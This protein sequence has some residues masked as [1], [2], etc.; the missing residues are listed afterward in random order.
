MMRSTTKGT[1]IW[2]ER[3]SDWETI[4]TQNS[5]YC[6]RS[7]ALITTLLSPAFLETQ[8]KGESLSSVP[9]NTWRDLIW[10]G[11]ICIGFPPFRMIKSTL[12]N[13]WRWIRKTHSPETWKN[14]LNSAFF[15]FQEVKDALFTTGKAFILTVPIEGKRQD[16]EEGYDFSQLSQ[17]VSQMK[18]GGGSQI[19]AFSIW[20]IKCGHFTVRFSN[21]HVNFFNILTMDFKWYSDETE[22]S[23]KIGHHSPLRPKDG[24]SELDRNL[25]V[26]SKTLSGWGQRNNLSIYQKR[27]KIR[28]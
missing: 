4:E 19:F 8:G 22:A 21:R 23:Q 9:W 12:F 18:N 3:L 6:S 16:I 27:C 25:T 10:M 24:E 17:W 5:K 26:V 7:V 2:S 1:L 20:N 15:I 14:K 11:W 28:I 13:S